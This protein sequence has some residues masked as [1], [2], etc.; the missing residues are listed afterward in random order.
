VSDTTNRVNWGA[1]GASLALQQLLRENF[2][3]VQVLPGHYATEPVPVNFSLPRSIALPLFSRRG[4]GAIFKLYYE[5]EKMMGAKRDYIQDEPQQS[6]N[7]I[8]NGK[9]IDRLRDLYE[10]V[11]GVD[12]VVIDGNGDLIF[13]TPAGRISKYH[14][15]LIQLSDK[16]SKEVHYINSIFADCP[17]TGRNEILFRHAIDALSKCSTVALRDPTSVEL[18]QASVPNVHVEYVPD[19][20]FLWNDDLQDAAKNLPT[21]GDYVIPF[22]REQPGRYGQIRFDQPYVCLA[23]G[24][25]AAKFKDKA[26]Q[27][28]IDLA[29]RLN[30]AL[31]CN[32]YLTPT[33][34]GDSFMYEVAEKTGMPILPAE[35]P[36]MMAGAIVGCARLLITGRYHPAIMASLNGTPCVFLGADSHKTRSLQRMLGYEDVRLLSALPTEEECDKICELATEYMNQ[37]EGLSSHIRQAAR[38]CAEEARGLIS[39]VDKRINYQ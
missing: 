21:S 20:L 16:L 5:I 36:I 14:L 6:A 32:V 33:C 23:G 29:D 22:T 19:S 37:G 12:V 8:I 34:R 27:S 28:Y 9:D 17:I 39:L 10:K 31:D 7:S 2:S 26:I 3:D 13:K 4:N 18:A 1:R 30:H 11:A 35:I 25:M 15:A 38:N 24:S